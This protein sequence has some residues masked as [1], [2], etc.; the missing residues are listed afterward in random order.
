MKIGIVAPASRLESEMAERVNAI[1]RTQFGAR[2]ELVF[3]PQCFLKD[4]HFA[5]E[6]QARANAFVEVANDPS[7]DAIWFARGG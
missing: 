3:H 5:G 2:A 4:G 7:F 1:A 6:D